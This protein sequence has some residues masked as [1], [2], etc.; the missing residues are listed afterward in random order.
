MTLS[1]RVLADSVVR[2]EPLSAAHADAM[3]A[4]VDVG[5]ESFGYTIVPTVETVDAYIAARLAQTATGTHLSF[6]QFDQASGRLVGHTSFTN[7]RDWPGRAQLLAVEVGHTWLVPGA[8]G[9]AVNSAAKLLLFTHAFEALGVLRLELKTDARNA[10]SRAGIAAVGASFEGI[11][12]N[13][14]P[15][16]VPGEE[17]L[18]RDT[19]MFS[20]T[21][22]QWPNTKSA[23]A[24]R[25][26]AKIR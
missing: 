4:A 26:A 23:L 14:Q 7:A 20:I 25:V 16:A 22:A 6:A 24:A 21:A 1:A 12:R 13:W 10:R 9:T 5:R 17:D 19:A 3:R 15:S 18:L 11:L 8:Q 2:L